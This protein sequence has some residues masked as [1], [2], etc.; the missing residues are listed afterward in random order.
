MTDEL[1]IKAEA[2]FEKYKVFLRDVISK[3]K[4]LDVVRIEKRFGNKFNVDKYETT[5][6]STIYLIEGEAIEDSYYHTKMYSKFEEGK[7]V[8]LYE[9]HND[10]I[11]IYET[12]GLIGKK[13]GKILLDSLELTATIYK[14][15]DPEMHKPQRGI[16]AV[17]KFEYDK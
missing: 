2:I 1:K 16:I 13:N 17:I 9:L 8:S 7:E 15:D 11:R 6:D 4:D 14:P 12:S 3:E 10:F 5:R